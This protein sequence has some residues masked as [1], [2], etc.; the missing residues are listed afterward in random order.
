MPAVKLIVLSAMIESPFL[1]VE[2]TGLLPAFSFAAFCGAVSQGI[3]W[4]G[5]VEASVL[6]RY[7]AFTVHYRAR[8]AELE[9]ILSFGVFKI[10]SERFSTMNWWGDIFNG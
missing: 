7:P 5:S 10:V 2:C 4:S 6:D 3:Q 1:G 8:F 9:G